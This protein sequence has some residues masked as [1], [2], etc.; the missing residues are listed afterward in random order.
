MVY[1][2]TSCSPAFYTFTFI[3]LSIPFIFSIT[4]TTVPCCTCKGSGTSIKCTSC[5]CVRLKRPCTSCDPGKHDI[6]SN[7]CT[8]TCSTSHVATAQS[9]PFLPYLPASSSS[10]SDA[11]SQLSP[12]PSVPTPQQSSDQYQLSISNMLPEPPST[13]SPLTLNPLSSHS[14]RKRCLVPGCTALLA[15]TMW[16]SH[17]SLHACGLFPGDVP[18]S[19]M[20][21][22][23]LSICTSCHQLVS[24]TRTVS[25]RSRCRFRA[26]TPNVHVVLPP[27]NLSDTSTTSHSLPSLEEI[28]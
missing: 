6:C 24:N 8:C 28:F 26:I 9:V 27:T 10:S 14:T 1:Y 22:Q 23:N 21:D 17:M 18:T 13:D 7:T 16:H 11:Q 19:W 4:T 20:T 5:I 25:H 12:S 15:P 3:I 2:S